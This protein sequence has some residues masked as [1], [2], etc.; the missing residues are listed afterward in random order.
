[1]LQEF[2]CLV[3][4]ITL[5][6]LSQEFCIQIITSRGQIGAGSTALGQGVL[7]FKVGSSLGLDSRTMGS[8]LLLKSLNFPLPSNK[9]IPQRST[10]SGKTISSMLVLLNSGIELTIPGI[11]VINKS[12]KVGNISVKLS[13][14][15]LVFLDRIREFFNLAVLFLELRTIGIK[16]QFLSINPIC[17]VGDGE[18]AWV[19]ILK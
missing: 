1:M 3:Q 8:N 14:E 13:I 6:A 4:S 16:I 10:I 18:I 2:I 11:T 17:V 19:G 7:K 5:I 12:L 15:A 9:H